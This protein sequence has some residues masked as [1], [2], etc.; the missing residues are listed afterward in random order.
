MKDTYIR[1]RCSEEEKVLIQGM[2]EQS[3]MNMSEYILDL[4]RADKKW[5]HEVEVFIV[6]KGPNKNR[7]VVEKFRQSLGTI[8]VDD[9]NRASVYTTYKR[10]AKKAYELTG[11][12]TKRPSHYSY[13]EVNGEEVKSPSPF[14]DWA[15]FGTPS[16]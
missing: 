10:L 2:A 15:I 13:F 5:Y 11:E 12:L 8:L 1:L 3:G 16:N 9:Q 14:S 7:D 4:V 6:V